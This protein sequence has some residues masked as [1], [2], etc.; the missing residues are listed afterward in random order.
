MRDE[1]PPDSKAG[2]MADQACHPLAADQS[3]ASPAATAAPQ[4]RTGLA[5]HAIG[6]TAAPTIGSSSGSCSRSASPSPAPPA[7]A[8]RPVS[9]ALPVPT[10]MP[11]AIAVASGKGGVGKTFL[12]VNLSVALA[13]AGLRVGLF[14]ADVGLANANLLLG[15]DPAHSP[16]EV[17]D[18]A[19]PLEEALERGPAGVRLLSSGRGHAT[20]ADLTPGA[21]ERW[22]AAMAPLGA[23]LD[24]MVIDTA[25]GLSAP[26][27][28]FTASAALVLIV[29][30]PEP[31]AFMDAYALIKALAQENGRREF[32]IAANQVADAAEGQRLFDQ[33]ALVARRFLPVALDWAGA[34]PHDPL[35]RKA[36]LERAPLL[37]LRPHAPAAIAIT[38]LG[39]R[40]AARLAEQVAARPEPG[41]RAAA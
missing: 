16:D 29:L 21:S 4:G 10:P 22:L 34:V 20:L 31:A 25:P 23:T 27:R 1:D 17:A 11:P 28:A 35:A 18:G 13:R 39:A 26:A 8:P 19:C 3:G 15:L 5:G 37:E 6:P 33:F 41:A 9:G 30:T 24:L 2:A 12:A 7:E 14:D 32:W 40:L 36:A 38:R